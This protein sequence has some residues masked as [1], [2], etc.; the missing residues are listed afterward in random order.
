MLLQDKLKRYTYLISL[1]SFSIPNICD[2]HSIEAVKDNFSSSRGIGIQ[3]HLIG[4]SILCS[5]NDFARGIST[6]T[7]FSHQR[8]LQIDSTPQRQDVSTLSCELHHKATLAEEMDDAIGQLV[9]QC[10]WIQEAWLE[11]RAS[12]EAVQNG[13]RRMGGLAC[14]FLRFGISSANVWVLPGPMT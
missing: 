7:A 5:S 13:T 4:R 6:T 9:L 8:E 14:V 2:E 1:V 10:C 11:V 12:S 3:C